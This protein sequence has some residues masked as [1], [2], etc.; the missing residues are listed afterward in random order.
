[1]TS[2]VALD[3]TRAPSPETTRAS[4][5][6]H[7][8]LLGCGNV[9]S[10]FAA[11]TR[12]AAHTTLRVTHALVRDCLRPR[13]A[14]D[15]GA[16]RVAS[17]AAIFEPPPDVVV[18]LLG[19]IEPARSLVLESLYRGIPVVTAN[20]SL[21]AAHGAELR[22]VATR[23]ST[24]LLYEAAVIAGVPFLGNFARRPHAAD[25]N[26][27]V[28]IANGTSNY[29]LTRARDARCG[30]DAALAEAR[31]RG[32]A[33]PDPSNDIDGIDAAEKLVVLLQH[34]A[35]AGRSHRFN[36]NRRDPLDRLRGCR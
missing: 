15:P 25:V 21:L 23:T 13:P 6:I 11:L 12:G 26:G 31:Q 28:G 30:I 10:A 17:G 9:G 19:G 2:A 14:L 7:V 8:G 20:K 27:L 32:Y 22:E 36:R 33:E 3:P 4:S 29:I 34:F 18:E 1:M 24:P 35:H 16:L 5:T